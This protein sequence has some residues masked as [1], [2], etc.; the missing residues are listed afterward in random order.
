M[1]DST[2]NQ[3]L[4]AP[5]QAAARK[6]HAHRH[7][8]RPPHLGRFCCG[9]AGRATDCHRAHAL[10]A[11]GHGAQ[12]PGRRAG[13]HT[14]PLTTPTDRGAF[15][16][17]ALDFLFYA[18]I[19]LAFALAN[20]ADNALAAAVLLF[21]FMGTGSSFLAFA[22]LAAKRQLASTQYPRQRLFLPGWADRGHRNAGCVHADV[23]SA[24][25]VRTAGLWV[26]SAVRPDHGHAHR[27]RGDGVPKRPATPLNTNGPTRCQ[28]PV[29]TPGRGTQRSLNAAAT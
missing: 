5:L 27:G 16:D 19:P 25:L 23:P 29:D 12:P 22:V 26:C 2:L 20:P 11:G 21:G 6:L 9:P 7:S 4:K 13:R 1:L 3:W 8:A 24:R 10:G 15:L 14:G 18:S 17:I 28:C